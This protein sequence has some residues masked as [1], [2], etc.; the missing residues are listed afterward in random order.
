MRSSRRRLLLLNEVFMTAKE[1]SAW[2]NPANDKETRQDE[3]R[4]VQARDRP[5]PSADDAAVTVDVA[6]RHNTDRLQQT[7]MLIHVISDGLLTAHELSSLMIPLN[8]NT[9]LGM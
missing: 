2:L 9:D 4:H 1:Q 6:Q 7:D 5:S 3:G 8:R